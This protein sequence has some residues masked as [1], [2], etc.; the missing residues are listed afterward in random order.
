MQKKEE[1]YG[2]KCLEVLQPDCVISTVGK[3]VKVPFR[4]S[5][6]SNAVTRL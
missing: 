2:Y 6:L 5:A 3:R 4:V 1:A